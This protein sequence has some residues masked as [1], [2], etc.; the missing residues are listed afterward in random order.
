MNLPE[1]YPAV[2]Q[3]AADYS[4]NKPPDFLILLEELISRTIRLLND[5]FSLLHLHIPE[6][7]DSRSFSN[8]LQFILFCLGVIAFFASIIFFVR[9]FQNRQAAASKRIKSATSANVLM[10][11]LDWQQEGERLAE[12]HRWR[13]ACRA[14]YFAFLRLLD[15]KQILSF[16]S[17]RTNYEYSKALSQNKDLSD[18]LRG[19]VEV[20]ESAWFGNYQA[21]PSDFKSCRNLLLSASLLLDKDT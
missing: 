7:S 20:V 11:S 5:L 3:V 18:V 4:Y 15:E 21:Q 10:S 8:L 14:I 1:I 17:T 12:S 6:S 16:S 19:L 2:E 13:E 9:R